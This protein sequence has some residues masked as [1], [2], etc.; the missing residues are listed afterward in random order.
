ML[1][2]LQLLEQNIVELKDRYHI[3]ATELINLKN[4]LASDTTSDEINKLQTE[5][6]TARKALETSNES[7]ETL[8]RTNVALEK[9]INELC[10][11][12]RQLSIK[13]QELENKTA[14][15]ISRAEVIQNWLTNIDNSA[16]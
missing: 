13:N 9:Q 2:Q 7:V 15:A 8:E 6:A 10:E 11:Q 12:N 5:L 4:R 3:T 16:V 14:L 1:A